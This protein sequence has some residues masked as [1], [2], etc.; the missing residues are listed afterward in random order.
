MPMG[1]KESSG[2][3]AEYGFGLVIGPGM[4]V[5]KVLP[6]WMLRASLTR[7]GGNN[8]HRYR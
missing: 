1:Q 4:I 5:L 2:P 7:F 6:Q 8:G 3:L